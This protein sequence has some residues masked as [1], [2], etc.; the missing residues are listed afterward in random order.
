MCHIVSWI[1][2]TG[3]LILPKGSMYNIN[4]TGSS[5]NCVE[6][7][8]PRPCQ[9]SI[10]FVIKH[11]YLS[12]SLVLSGSIPRQKIYL[13]TII[14]NDNLITICKQVYQQFVMNTCLV[15]MK[16]RLYPY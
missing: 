8:N 14:E 2:K 16:V 4:R 1:D 3:L 15:I 5:W 9:F 13:I 12:I 11:D 6:L 10:K 7:R